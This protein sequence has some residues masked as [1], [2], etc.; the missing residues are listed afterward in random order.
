MMPTA[1]ASPYFAN[2]MTQTDAALQW[3]GNG[4]LWC[5]R[6]ENRAGQ[7]SYKI[8]RSIE[9]MQLSI[10]LLSMWSSPIKN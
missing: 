8:E 2:D 6:F 1:R 7:H 5:G 3:M 10:M 9:E 4:R